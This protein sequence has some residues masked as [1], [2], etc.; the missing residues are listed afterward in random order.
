[1]RWTATRSER[2]VM[3]PVGREMPVSARRQEAS[4]GVAYLPDLARPM[5]NSDP[6]RRAKDDR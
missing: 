2:P 4:V 5:R 6:H 3:P 1:L